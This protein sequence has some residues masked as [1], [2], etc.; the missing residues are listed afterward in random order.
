MQHGVAYV[1]AIKN[2][3]SSSALQSVNPV[4]GTLIVTERWLRKAVEETIRFYNN[5]PWQ[6]SF[7]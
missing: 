3:I 7:S 2:N 4:Q 5:C 1:E 6:Q